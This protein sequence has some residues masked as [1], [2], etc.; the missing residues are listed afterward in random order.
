[1]IYKHQFIDLVLKWVEYSKHL[2]LNFM[3]DCNYQFVGRI[4][5]KK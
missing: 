2:N 5:I 4:G 1:M 3:Q